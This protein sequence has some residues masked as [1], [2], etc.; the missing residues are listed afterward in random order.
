M[1]GC[2]SKEVPLLSFYSFNF[3]QAHNAES[4]CSYPWKENIGQ[5]NIKV[6]ICERKGKRGPKKENFKKGEICTCRL[7][8]CK[9]VTVGCFG[10]GGIQFSYG[11]DRFMTGL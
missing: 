3:V 7:K 6:G 11:R 1:N 2:I 10:G 5:K 9:G 4:N 8:G